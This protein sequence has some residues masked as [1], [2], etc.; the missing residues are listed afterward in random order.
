MEA[1]SHLVQ[2]LPVAHRDTLFYLLRFLAKVARFSDDL[3]KNDGSRS[4]EVEDET[5]VGNKMDSNNLATVFAPNILHNSVSGQ[6]TTDQEVDERIDVI[7]V[8]RWAVD[9]WWK[10]FLDPIF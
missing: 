4:L 7:N 10:S 1:L 9:P 5:A 8:I 6:A 3:Y 2:L